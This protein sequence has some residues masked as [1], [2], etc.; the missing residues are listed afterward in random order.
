MN[1]KRTKIYSQGLG[2]KV[3]NLKFSNDATL[4]SR[5]TKKGHLTIQVVPL[6]RIINKATFIKLDIEGAE[7][8]A[9]RGAKKIIIKYSPKLVICIYHKSTD[10]WR[11]P[12]LIKKYVSSY[13]FY[14][15]HYGQFIYGTVCYAVV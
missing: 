11:I 13:S 2:E 3:A 6:D 4:G 7:K 8:E 12:L 1:D 14:L 9:L 15:R 5:I 10:L